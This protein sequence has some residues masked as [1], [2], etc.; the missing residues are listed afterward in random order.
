MLRHSF[1][2]IANNL[3]FTEIM[4]ADTMSGYVKALLEDVEFRWNTYTLDRQS[5]KSA[6]DQMLT[7]SRPAV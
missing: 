1:A 2:S 6:I 5:R 7:E 4:A 3:G